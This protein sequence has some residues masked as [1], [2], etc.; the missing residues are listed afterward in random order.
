M[1]TIK[2]HPLTPALAIATAALIVWIIAIA[3]PGQPANEIAYWAYL[4]RP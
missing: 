2:D 1:Q 3:F 4:L